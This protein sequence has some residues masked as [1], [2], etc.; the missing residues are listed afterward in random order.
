MEIYDLYYKDNKIQYTLERKNIR[1][2]NIRLKSD[3]K[4]YVSAPY[5]VPLDFIQN[6]VS[7]KSKWIFKN[8]ADIEKRQNNKIDSDIYNN[9]TV[10]FMGNKFK[11]SIIK[12]LKNN[13]ILDYENMYINIYTAYDNSEY[14]KKLYLDWLEFNCNIVFKESVERMI[15][16]LSDY[17][18]DFPK[19]SVRNMKTRWGSCTPSKKS[20]RLNLQLIKADIKCIDQ[21]VLHELVHFI[22]FNHSKDFYSVIKKYMPDYKERK[23]CLENNFKDGI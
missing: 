23:Y 15:E 14:I 6:F 20:I 2:V 7:S 17:N 12:D 18:I 19:I 3:K 22:Y 1:R 8:I 4:V 9:K 16:L 21:V 5:N 13:I 10:F 11:V